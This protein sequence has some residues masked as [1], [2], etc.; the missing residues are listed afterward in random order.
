MGELCPDEVKTLIAIRQAGGNMSPR[1]LHR[2]YKRL[3]AS[4][5]IDYDYGGHVLTYGKKHGSKPADVATGDRAVNNLM[6]K[7][8]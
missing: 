4:M 8:A 1:N 6:K 2:M 3:T 5:A 7:G